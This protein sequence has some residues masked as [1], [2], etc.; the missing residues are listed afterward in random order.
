MIGINTLTANQ[1][2]GVAMGLAGYNIV[3]PG[4]SIS[5]NFCMIQVFGQPDGKQVTYT[6]ADG[7]TGSL[8][9]LSSNIPDGIEFYSPYTTVSLGATATGAALIVYNIG[10]NLTA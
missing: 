10:I 5:G 9:A 4:Q 1:A 6:L 8:T 2:S 7:T 3:S